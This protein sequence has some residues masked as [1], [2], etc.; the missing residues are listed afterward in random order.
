[1]CQ[2]WWNQHRLWLVSGMCSHV[3]HYLLMPPSD[4]PGTVLIQRSCASQWQP[5]SSLRHSYDDSRWLLADVGVVVVD[6]VVA[7]VVVGVVVVVDGMICTLRPHCT[8]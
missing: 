1:M 2:S 7:E 5:G 3:K 8:C 4:V 6:V